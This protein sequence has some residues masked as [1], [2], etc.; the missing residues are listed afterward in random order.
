MVEPKY[1]ISIVLPDPYF[2]K[3]NWWLNPSVLGMAYC[4][5]HLVPNFFKSKKDRPKTTILSIAPEPLM[6]ITHK[7]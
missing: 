1:V 3:F 7:G 4:Q 6:C 2:L 5:T